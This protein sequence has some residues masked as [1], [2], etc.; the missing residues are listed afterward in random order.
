[1]DPRK[2]LEFLKKKENS[3]PSMTL[4]SIAYEFKIPYNELMEMPISTLSVYIEFLE[5]MEEQ[6]K[7]LLK[8][9]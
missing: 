2:K 5:K 1:L 9:K 6:N 3:D 7:K 8:K 4:L